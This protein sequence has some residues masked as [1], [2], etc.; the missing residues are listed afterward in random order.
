MTFKYFVL[1]V[2]RLM[3]E[4]VC[5]AFIFKYNLSQS[6]MIEVNQ[7]NSSLRKTFKCRTHIIEPVVVVLQKC[8]SFIY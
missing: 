4:K 5:A 1:L 7:A 6:S 8:I 3:V 2:F